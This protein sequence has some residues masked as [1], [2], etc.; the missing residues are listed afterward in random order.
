[1]RRVDATTPLRQINF[2]AFAPG[3]MTERAI[4]TYKWLLLRCILKILTNR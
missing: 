2:G 4:S 1:M 3:Q